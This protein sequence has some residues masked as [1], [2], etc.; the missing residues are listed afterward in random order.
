MS[1][2]PAVS[3]VRT[4]VLPVIVV[5]SPTSA[6][7]AWSAC[8]AI[9]PRTICSVNSFEPTVNEA[10]DRSIAAS[11]PPP[12]PPPAPPPPPPPPQAVAASTT[13]AS[14]ASSRIGRLQD[15][16]MDLLCSSLKALG[17]QHVFRGAAEVVDEEGEHSGEHAADDG[18]QRPV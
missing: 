8:T 6:P 16:C 18:H 11:E 17:P 10:P 13:V 12:L 7:V 14:P 3:A 4:L 9:W 15:C 2:S 5:R 1:S